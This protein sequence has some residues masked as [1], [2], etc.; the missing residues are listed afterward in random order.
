M[1]QLEL[2]AAMS[3][4]LQHPGVVEEQPLV[5]QF[6]WPMHDNPQ[7]DLGREEA[8]R[9]LEGFLG[10]QIEEGGVV[11]LICLGDSAA[12]RVSPLGLA[13]ARR[14]LPSTREI[15][16]TPLRKRDAWRELRA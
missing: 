5:A 4:A 10:R 1:E 12:S 13:C 7:F 3:R 9:S 8:A 11:E 2:I 6:D 16:A 14:R 15:L